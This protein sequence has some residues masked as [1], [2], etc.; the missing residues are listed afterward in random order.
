MVAE[1]EVTFQTH[2]VGRKGGSMNEGERAPQGGMKGGRRWGICIQ[3]WEHMGHAI[4]CGSF[5]PELRE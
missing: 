4:Y 2:C 3:N 1:H 5:T